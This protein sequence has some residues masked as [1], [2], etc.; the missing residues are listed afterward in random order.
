[1]AEKHI[2]TDL[3][4]RIRLDTFKAGLQA[5][6]GKKFTLTDAL[7]KLLDLGDSYLKEKPVEAEVPA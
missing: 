1:M 7:K 6:E 3:E 4:T 2:I 5:R